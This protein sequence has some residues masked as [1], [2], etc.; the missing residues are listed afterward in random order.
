MYLKL[1]PYKQRSLAKRPNQKLSLRF[2]GPYKIIQRVG[3]VAYK[4]ELPSACRIHPVFHVSQLKIAAGATASSQSGTP[5]T[6]DLELDAKPHDILNIRQPPTGVDEILVAWDG[7]DPADTTWEDRKIFFA[8]Y[9]FA[10][11]EDKVKVLEG[12]IVMNGG[13]PVGPVVKT[14]VRRGLNNK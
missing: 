10:H 12:G 9:P 6:D 5:V 4:L 14:Y 1:Q 11:L 8:A 2:F 3:D 13:Q 7:L